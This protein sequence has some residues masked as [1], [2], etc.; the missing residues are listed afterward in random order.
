M[1]LIHALTKL[2]RG[3]RRIPSRSASPQTAHLRI[4]NPFMG[5]AGR[6][7][8]AL[9]STHPPMQERIARLQN[10]AL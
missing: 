2:E 4:V 8:A 7:F 9:F 10:L 5:N 1:C 6:T 3:A